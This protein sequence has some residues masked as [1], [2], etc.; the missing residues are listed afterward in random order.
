MVADPNY[1]FQN[2]C[3]LLMFSV[4]NNNFNK[5]IPFL[6]SKGSNNFSYKNNGE[7]AYYLEQEILPSNVDKNI[8][9]MLKPTPQSAGTRRK[10]NYLLSNNIKKN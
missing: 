10:K 7:T 6:I 4:F 2:D 9:N 8:L 5:V 1:I 3:S